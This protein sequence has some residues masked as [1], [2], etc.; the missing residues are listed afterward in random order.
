M[1][2]TPM[3]SALILLL[4]LLSSAHAQESQCP[5][6]T[7]AE[8]DVKGL[9]SCRCGKELRNVTVTP[10][11]G[12]ELRAAC[13]LRQWETDGSSEI[14]KSRPVDLDSYDSRGFRLN[15]RYYFGGYLRLK[16]ILRFEPSDAGELFFY[17][18]APVTMPKT[19]LE[20]SFRSFTLIPNGRYTTY[21]IDQRI[22]T[23]GCAEALA[24]IVVKEVY[25]IVN[26]S[27]EAGAYRTVVE[28]VR[29]S[30]YKPCT[31]R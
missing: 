21:S 18:P 8:N 4:A 6:L 5:T 15:G 25:V 20:P 1:T 11:K 29:V 9:S 14:P 12:L 27:E 26:D 19:A 7:R 16:G 22:R 28:L 30:P 13:S 2:Y 10:P 3:R 24:E 23:L 17:P 31:S